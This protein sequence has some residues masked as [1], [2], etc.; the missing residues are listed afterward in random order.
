MYAD[1]G[2][3]ADAAGPA[4]RHGPGVAAGPGRRRGP[5]VQLFDSWVGALSPD[6]YR[7]FVLPASAKVLGGLADLGVPRIHFGVG[8]GELLGLMAEAG[9]DVVGVDWRV[10][11]DQARRRVGPDVALQ[12]N[13]DPAVCWPAGR[14]PAAG[15]ARSWPP[16]ASAG[17]SSIWATASCRRPIP[18]SWPGWS[19][20]ATRGGPG[21]V[22]VA[23]VG[24]GIA[25]L[26]AAW[27]LRQRA[28]AAGAT[29]VTVFEPDRLG[30]CIRTTDFAGHLV[31]EGP[32]AFLD[33]GPRSG[34]AVPGARDQRRAGRP[35]RGPFDAVVARPAAAPPGGPGARRP[36]PARPA[37]RQRDP[38]PARRAPGRPRPG[39]ARGR[40]PGALTVRE[41]VAGR[42]GAEVA[43]RLVD[44]LV[45]GIHAGSTGE[46]GAAEVVPQLVAAAD[47]LPQPAAR[48]A[49]P[50]RPRCAAAGRRSF[51][52]AGRRRAAWSTSWSTPLAEHGDAL[53][54]RAVD[55]GPGR[56]AR[57]RS[58]WP[59]SPTRSTRRWS[60]RRPRVAAARLLAARCG[61]TG[62]GRHPHRLGGP[63]HRRRSPGTRLPPGVNGFLVPA[64]SG[65]PDD[66]L[67]VR[68][69]QVAALGRTWRAL[70]RMSAGRYGDDRAL[71]LDDAALTDRLLAELERGP[72]RRRLAGGGASVPLA[73]RLPA[74]PSGPR[75]PDHAVEAALADR[76]PAVALAGASYRGS[77]IPACIASGRRAAQLGWSG[78]ARRP[79]DGDRNSPPRTR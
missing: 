14:Y 26:A 28:D 19:S 1:P 38:V 56:P 29:E 59:R 41:L 76:L 70:V 34:P 18:T 61:P 25:G 23:V 52:P 35:G 24:G 58:W 7:R 39:P 22:R 51:S 43:D 32:D 57:R 10:P 8:T 75:R 6:D 4:G 48:P 2:L 69:Q 42:F 67:L 60:P 17:T 66:R 72:R 62:A 46:L 30:G 54:G 68:L 77:G 33:P 50:G 36:P 65:P 13:L 31:D 63:G 53:R 40:P 45:G 3:W 15:R 44:P 11:L 55:S 21:G 12:G 49:R 27:E 79:P 78:R 64:A 9:A 20:C 71:E 73:R 37:G 16:A 47:A 5:A 74:V